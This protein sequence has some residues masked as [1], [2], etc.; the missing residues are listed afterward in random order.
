MH[1][2]ADNHRAARSTTAAAARLAATSCRANTAWPGTSCTLSGGTDPTHSGAAR[3]PRRS[4]TNSPRD[5]APCDA[6]GCS[7]GA[8]Q[9]AA[10]AT[11]NAVDPAECH[12]TRNGP[13]P[14]AATAGGSTGY[15]SARRSATGRCPDAAGTD[16]T[17]GRTSY[18][19]ARCSTTR[20]RPDP[21]RTDTT[22]GSTS[23]HS[24]RC[25][26]ARSRPDPAGTDATA[27]STGRRSAGRS[28]RSCSDLAGTAATARN[29]RSGG[30]QCAG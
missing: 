23:Y 4:G 1:L 30:C 14:R 8:R 29:S 9:S 16:T 2:L 10:P 24:A 11:G 7:A 26:T 5:A 20:S 21:A 15:H 17:A 19:S 28:A 13:D 27:G 22:A 3:T 6:P 25:S 18:H 12:V